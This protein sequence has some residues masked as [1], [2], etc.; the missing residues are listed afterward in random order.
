M[1]GELNETIK[2]TRM[3]SIAI[4]DNLVKDINKLW[5]TGATNHDCLRY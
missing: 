4:I 3:K 1:L 2:Q 5:A